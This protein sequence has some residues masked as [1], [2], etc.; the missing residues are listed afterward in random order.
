M[1]LVL[2]FFY[3]TSAQ[4]VRVIRVV[5]DLIIHAYVLKMFDPWA[6]HITKQP[7]DNYKRLFD[8]KYKIGTRT[9]ESEIRKISL[10]KRSTYF[11]HVL[12]TNYAQ[13][14]RHG[15][16][17]RTKLITSWKLSF[18][19]LHVLPTCGISIMCYNCEILI[20]C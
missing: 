20:M 8:C 2:F 15:T 16:L 1:L 19:L 3:L 7:Q 13:I 11:S 14:G 12:C 10:E 17:Y 18:H 4:L 9:H 6:F 5:L